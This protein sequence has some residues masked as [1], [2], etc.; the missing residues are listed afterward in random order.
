MLAA[1]V[2]G[3]HVLSVVVGSAAGW[4]NIRKSSTATLTSCLNYTLRISRFSHTISS[5]KGIRAT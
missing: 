4:S 1:D 2:I 5:L 3:T